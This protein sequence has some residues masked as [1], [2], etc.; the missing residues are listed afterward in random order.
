MDWGWATR[1]E[2]GGT[3]DK[4]MVGMRLLK[5]ENPAP[6]A[7]TPGQGIRLFS[8]TFKA[9]ASWQIGAWISISTA[10]AL[11][12]AADGPRC[13]VTFEAQPGVKVV[14]LATLCNRRLLVE[15]CKPGF[16][17]G[18]TAWQQF[19]GK[20]GRV[21]ASFNFAFGMQVKGSRSS[22]IAGPVAGRLTESGTLSLAGCNAGTALSL[23]QPRS[24]TAQ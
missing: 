3:A 14:S 10:G 7:A 15:N 2:A 22:Q 4:R 13:R 23:L 20:W 19:F 11:P 18:C 12:L 24:P 9:P 16:F 21:P 17:P 6:L 8:G 5:K 1:T